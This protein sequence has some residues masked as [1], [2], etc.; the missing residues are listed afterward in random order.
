MP[1][2]VP[3][4]PG[5]RRLMIRRSMRSGLSLMLLALWSLSVAAAPDPFAHSIEGTRFQGTRPLT[6]ELFHVQGLALGARRLWITSVDR[7]HRRGYLHEFDR[8]SG[9]IVRR[10]ELTDGARF[11]PGGISIDGDSIWVPVAELRPDS[12]SVLLEIDAA[13]LHV[14][15]RIRVADHLGCV[16]V[17]QGRL[18]AG[19]WDS[20]L[21]YV[22]D[23][24]DLSRVHV[25]RNPSRTRFQDIKL[26]DGTLVASG[27]QSWWSGSVDMIDA[28]TMTVRRALHAGSIGPIAGTYTGEG[29]AIEGRDL[30]LVP[31]DGPSR[32]FHF[33]L[34]APVTTA[35]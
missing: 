1:R 27:A 22:A 34:D 13:T 33:R 35:T 3:G 18:I 4:W 20:R 26:I 7:R 9:R 23:L 21:F 12:S 14:R 31:E 30:Y 2:P 10:I 32:L 29:M 6:G 24:S 5:G 11:H 28:R 25:V 8:A 16:A 15:R 17:A 19:N